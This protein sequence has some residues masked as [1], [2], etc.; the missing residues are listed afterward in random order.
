[1]RLAI[2]LLALCFA[3]DVHAQPPAAAPWVRFPKPNTAAAVPPDVNKL[4]GENLFVIEGDKPFAVI[5]TGGLVKV[6][7]ASGPVSIFARFVD[8]S[9]EM[10]LRSFNAKYLA[11]VQPN[12]T[13]SATLVIVPQDWKSQTDFIRRTVQV[14]NG[15][16][17]RPPPKPDEPTPKPPATDTL[18]PTDGK[19]RVLILEETKDRSKL[20]PAQAAA[21]VGV[22]TREWLES[23]CSLDADG[24]TKAYRIFDKDAVLVSVPDVWVR[25][26]TKARG[27]TVPTLVINNGREEY[28]GP[29]PVDGALPLLKQY[30][31]K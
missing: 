2:V 4:T 23:N 8:G 10:E 20:T 14:D 26:V 27:S 18:F 7:E 29:L 3:T 31:A 28:F 17:P 21:I 13:G 30:K 25:A 11:I 16:A 5:E 6:K 24:V 1:M 22:P 19:F 12:G 9:G 15:T